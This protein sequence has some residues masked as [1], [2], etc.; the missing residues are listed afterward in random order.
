MSGAKIP[1]RGASKIPTPPP[2]GCSSIHGEV[3]PRGAQL[4]CTG[5]LQE[6]CGVRASSKEVQFT[7]VVHTVSTLLLQALV[8]KRVVASLLGQVYS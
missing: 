6:G 1:A 8:S 7:L 5:G 4:L 3:L 2:R